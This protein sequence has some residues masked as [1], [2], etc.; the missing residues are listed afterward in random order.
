[1]GQRGRETSK[2]MKGL[3]SCVLNKVPTFSFFTGPAY[4][5]AGLCLMNYTICDILLG[6]AL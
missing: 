4:Y 5:I 3:L 2:E 6:F 1:M